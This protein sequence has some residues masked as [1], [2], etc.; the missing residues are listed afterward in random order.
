LNNGKNICFIEN[1]IRKKYE[2]KKH[3]KFNILACAE[4]EVL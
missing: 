4:D 3:G 2:K 1:I